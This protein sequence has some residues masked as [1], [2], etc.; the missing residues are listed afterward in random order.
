M[1]MVMVMIWVISILPKFRSYSPT[2]HPSKSSWRPPNTQGFYSPPR[3]LFVWTH[4]HTPALKAPKRPPALWNL[5]KEDWLQAAVHS[6][7]QRSNVCAVHSG[8]RVCCSLQA[9]GVIQCS[10]PAWAIALQPV[11]LEIPKSSSGPREAEKRNIP[12]QRDAI[13]GDA[14][15]LHGQSHANTVPPRALGQRR[16]PQVP[17]GGYKVPSPPL[18]HRIS[19]SSEIYL[20][21]IHNIL[22]VSLRE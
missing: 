8:F 5:F 6:G 13:R 21:Q 7:F 10:P 4:I 20:W 17:H 11:P 12:L 14:A 1:V 9:G 16:N 3:R 15:V 2:I 22:W 18:A 19:A